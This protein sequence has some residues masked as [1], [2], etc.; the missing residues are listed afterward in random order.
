MQWEQYHTR[1]QSFTTY[2][3]C[4]HFATELRGRDPRSA[5]IPQRI[6]GQQA[7]LGCPVAIRVRFNGLN[8]DIRR[9]REDTHNYRED[10][11][12]KLSSGLRGLIQKEAEKGYNASAVRQTIQAG[13]TTRAGHQT[14]GALGAKLIT[15]F[16]VH[17]AKRR[18][19]VIVRVAPAT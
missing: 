13:G 16:N 5:P 1:G 9:V 12:S 3:R 14:A 7:P 4:K 17:N 15:R 10:W 19:R 8:I 2:Y 6:K 18:S 11:G